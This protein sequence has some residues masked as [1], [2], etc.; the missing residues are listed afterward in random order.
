MEPGR[1]GPRQNHSGPPT[2]QM[3]TIFVVGI[4]SSQYY[5]LWARWISIYLQRTV[6]VVGLTNEPLTVFLG[7]KLLSYIGFFFGS[8]RCQQLLCQTKIITS[9]SHGDLPRGLL[10]HVDEE[11]RVGV[12]LQLLEVSKDSVVGFWAKYSLEMKIYRELC[13]WNILKNPRTFKRDENSSSR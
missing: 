12:L 9:W 13:F 8:N 6:N 7:N 11:G 10:D 4:V 5:T 3:N 2:Y 1:M